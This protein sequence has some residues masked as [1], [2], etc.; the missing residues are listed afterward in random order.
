MSAEK[1]LTL[2]E[3]KELNNPEA[4]EKEFLHPLGT[5]VEGQGVYGGAFYHARGH[6]K[7]VNPEI[8]EG[9]A[10][11]VLTDIYTT[12]TPLLSEDAETAFMSK[13]RGVNPALKKLKEIYGVR[14]DSIPLT[15]RWIG[16]AERRNRWTLPPANWL[17]LTLGCDVA[18]HVVPANDGWLKHCEDRSYAQ[19]FAT[20]SPANL[21]HPHHCL[22]EHLDGDDDIH[23]L[24][25]VFSKNNGVCDAPPS[26]LAAIR[27]A[28]AVE[29]AKAK[30]A[31]DVLPAT[32]SRLHPTTPFR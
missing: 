13:A 15:D 22:Q 17:R 23:R 3:I 26:E 14:M 12:R 1:I 4:L 18:G 21:R 19:S 20:P 10:V 9:M 2:E 28:R 6:S 8:P 29:R 25:V 31:S 11:P 27:P 7:Y 32:A 24:T 5:F 30:D 16:L